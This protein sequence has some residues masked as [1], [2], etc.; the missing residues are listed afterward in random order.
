MSLF[1]PPMVMIVY[2]SLELN[3]EVFPK[4]KMLHSVHGNKLEKGYQ[5]LCIPSRN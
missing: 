2:C 5:R 1:L 3:T 4:E